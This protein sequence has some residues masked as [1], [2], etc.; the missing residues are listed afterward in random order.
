MKASSFVGWRLSLPGKNGSKP[1]GKLPITQIG[2]FGTV[3]HGSIGLLKRSALYGFLLFADPTHLRDLAD[4]VGSEGSFAGGVTMVDRDRPDLF[5]QLEGEIV[6]R[7]DKTTCS[8]HKAV[9]RFT[10]AVRRLVDDLGN[11]AELFL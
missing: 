4:V 11:V 6:K 7:F 5:A 1:S 3:R 8:D 10:H 9:H 2:P